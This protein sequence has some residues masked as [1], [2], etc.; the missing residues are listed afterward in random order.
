MVIEIKSQGGSS[1]LMRTLEILRCRIPS[2]QG[3]V[4]PEAYLKCEKKIELVSVCH[5]YLE[6]KM[7]KLVAIEFSDYAIIWWGQLTMN[8]RRNGE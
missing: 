2:F 4:G 7:V 3:R 1:K 5:N 6:L 8:R